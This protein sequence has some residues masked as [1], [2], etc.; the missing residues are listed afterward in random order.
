[1][2]ALLVL[3]LAGCGG[4]DRTESESDDRDTRLA[5]VQQ[6]LR[7]G[8]PEPALVLVEKVG[9]LFGEDGETLALKG[10]ILHRLEKFEQA[11]ATFDASLKIEPTGELHLDRAISLTALQ[12]HEEAEAA[13]AAAEAMFTE[14]LEGRSYDV[15]LKLHMAMIAHLRGNDQSAL[16]QINLIIAEHPDSSAAR[17]LKAEVQR[18]IN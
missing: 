15:V 5:E 18:S 7:E 16:D 9:R 2:Q 17:E 11:V 1:M 3:A 12:R 14:R 4:A 6:V 10:H 13:L 8:G